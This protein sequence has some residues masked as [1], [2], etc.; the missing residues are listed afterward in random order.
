MKTTA[1]WTDDFPPPDDL[2]TDDLPSQVDVAIVGG[3]FTG[4][5]AARALARGGAGVAVLERLHIG[6][7]ASS[8]NGGMTTTGLKEKPKSMIRRYGEKLGR[9]FW[10]ASLDAINCVEQIVRQE[11]IECY[12]ARYGHFAAATKPSHFDTMCRETEWMARELGHHWQIVTRQEMQSEIGTDVFYG[13][14]VDPLSGGLH[15]ARYVFGLAHAT[16]RA[17][18]ALC[19]NTEVR[20]IG[21]HDGAFDITT[22]RG[23]LRAD[24]VLI[25][26]NGYT[27]SLVPEV[28]RRVVPI[29][30]YI[31]VTEPLPPELQ[32]RISPQGRMFYTSNWF[33]NYFRLTPDGRMLFGGR[34]NLSTDLDLVESARRLCRSMT[35]VFPELRDV[36]ITHSWTGQLGLTFDMMPHIGHI[37]GIHYALGYC[38]HGVA[39]ATYL[40]TEVAELMLGRR[41]RSPFAEITHPVSFFYR[42]RPWFLPL[43]AAYFRLLDRFA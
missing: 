33:L 27:G 36:P 24:E 35:R 20:A 41:P 38:G 12:F 5:A 6:G 13:G 10:Q 25:A 28:R 26:T 18:A 42:Q 19:A 32:Q 15:P 16:A 30:S 21:R 1:F 22:S 23:M 7:G 17:G 8:V 3:G 29:G 14:V 2:G 43:A 31:I 4:L 37:G 34:Q 39:I 40:G 9:E 11:G